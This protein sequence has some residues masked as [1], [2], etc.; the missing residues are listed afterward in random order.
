MMH[1]LL[2]EDDLDLGNGLLLALTMRGFTCEWVRTA[3]AAKEK[4]VGAQGHYACAVLDLGL[5]DGD[6]IEVLS[7][8]RRRGS[9]L[10][11]IVLT[12]RDTLRS[13]IQGLDSGADDYL[14]KPINSD[15]LVARVNALIR[16]YSG[17]ATPTWTVGV[18]DISLKRRELRRQGQLVELSKMEFELVIAL[19][20]SAGQVVSK[21]RLASMLAPLGEP[22]EFNALEVHVHNVRK[23]LGS[24]SIKTVRGVG[25]RIDV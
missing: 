15:E 9:D 10:P 2:V 21:N 11:V 6:G 3:R 25:Y 16:R 4:N 24:D 18:L 12:A 13:K 23:K 14:I 1:L 7:D 8:W 22:L 19:A 17:Q 20:Q 5:P